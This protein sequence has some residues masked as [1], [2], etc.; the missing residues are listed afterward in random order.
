MSVR[1][2]GIIRACGVP[3]GSNE[4]FAAEA[5][6]SHEDCWSSETASGAETAETASGAETE[7]AAPA[8][9]TAATETAETVE[10]AETESAGAETG[11]PR[12]ISS[13]GAVHLGAAPKR[14]RPDRQNCG[15]LP[16]P[17][18]WLLS[19]PYGRPVR[20]PQAI[21]RRGRAVRL[22]AAASGTARTATRAALAGAVRQSGT[23]ALVRR[24]RRTLTA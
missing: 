2:L 22:G 23:G 20:D 16:A 17:C 14:D 24:N 3:D 4:V 8:D 19:A 7:T 13:R 12:A 15:P 1:P 9:E 10:T 21:S 18:G 6:G 5:K 11:D